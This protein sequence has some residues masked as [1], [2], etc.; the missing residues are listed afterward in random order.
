MRMNYEIRAQ[1]IYTG[2]KGRISLIELVD[3]F[4]DGVVL[5]EIY[6]LQGELFDDVER[7]KCKED[8]EKRIK[9]LLE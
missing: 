2:K 4:S 5:W 6:S 8:A 1:Y 3:Y 9:E 7:F